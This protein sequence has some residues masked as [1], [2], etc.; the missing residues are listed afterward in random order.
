MKWLALAAIFVIFVVTAAL[1][2]SDHVTE[3]YTC[4]RQ[5]SVVNCVHHQHTQW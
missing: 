2:S 4:T 3:W 1:W 5:G